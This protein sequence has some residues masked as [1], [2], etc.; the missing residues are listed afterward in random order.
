MQ[1]EYRKIGRMDAFETI[2]QMAT[3]AKQRRG[4][5]SVAPSGQDGRG[6]VGRVISSEEE[7]NLTSDWMRMR[8]HVD[9][10]TSV[11]MA[12]LFDAMAAH[13][14]SLMMKTMSVGGDTSAEGSTSSSGANL[15]E[16]QREKRKRDL[17]NEA[18]WYLQQAESV[19]KQRFTGQ[20]SEWYHRLV[21]GIQYYCKKDDTKAAAEFKHSLSLFESRAARLGHA[22]V[23]IRAVKYVEAI[24]ELSRVYT[25]VYASYREKFAE[26][27]VDGIPS[28]AGFQQGRGPNDYNNPSSDFDYFR[29]T[30]RHAVENAEHSVKIEFLT[31]FSGLR[32]LMALVWSKLGAHDK[33]L[34]TLKIQLD[35]VEEG[36]AKKWI[37]A[38]PPLHDRTLS[39]L[40]TLEMNR[41]TE[42]KAKATTAE[43][44]AAARVVMKDCVS[45]LLRAFQLNSNNP[46]VLNQLANIF[47]VNPTTAEPDWDKIEGFATR[48]KELAQ[49]AGYREICAESCFYLGRSAHARGKFTTAR[50]HYMDAL[51]FSHLFAL[52]RFGLAQLAFKDGDHKGALEH[53]TKLDARIPD[54]ADT[55]AFL[56]KIHLLLAL[57]SSTPADYQT[58]HSSA[59]KFLERSIHLD[60]KRLATHLDLA[61]AKERSHPDRSLD[62]YLDASDLV[63]RG[64]IDSS[65]LSNAE[66]SSL[67]EAML[68]AATKKGDMEEDTKTS[69]YPH[70]VKRF[71]LNTA[72]MVFNNVAVMSMKTDKLTEAKEALLRAILLGACTLRASDAGALAPS[73]TSTQSS[74][75]NQF[76]NP[77]TYAEGKT[78][79]STAVT[80]TALFGKPL[81]EAL[82]SEILEELETFV[83][84]SKVFLLA[85]NV[86]SGYNLALCFEKSK[87]F[88][89]ATE[90]Y[91]A[92]LA[93]YPSYLDAKLRLAAMHK[94]MGRL[95]DAERELKE[96][97]ATSPTKSSSS[98]SITD[99]HLENTKS[100]AGVLLA[101]VLL[102]KKEYRDTKTMLDELV[103]KLSTNRSSANTDPNVAAQWTFGADVYSLTTYA[104]FFL[105]TSYSSQHREKNLKWATDLFM[106]VLKQSPGNIYAANGLAIVH[107]LHA[108]EE[109]AQLAASEEENEPADGENGTSGAHGASSH[110]KIGKST[111]KWTEKSR[112][113][114]NAFL[115][116]REAVPN[117]PDIL[118]NLGHLSFAVGDYRGA[119]KHYN[120]VWK[121]L[122]GESSPLIRMGQVTQM[123]ARCWF[124]LGN[125]DRARDIVASVLPDVA[126]SEGAEGD[127]STNLSSMAAG[128]GNEDYD[129]LRYNWAVMCKEWAT[130]ILSRLDESLKRSS[131]EEAEG[132]NEEDANNESKNTQESK[133]LDV[134]GDSAA[135]PGS[136]ATDSTLNTSSMDIDS[137]VT[138]SQTKTVKSET[139]GKTSFRFVSAPNEEEQKKA[140]DVLNEAK[141]IFEKLSASTIGDEASGAFK[142]RKISFSTKKCV[143]FAKLCEK[144]AELA[145][146]KLEMYREEMKKESVR[147]EEIRQKEEEAEASRQA[148]LLEQEEAIKKQ[149]EA[150]NEIAEA[151][152]LKSQQLM[153]EWVSSGAADLD[154]KKPRK[155]RTSS[156]RGNRYDSD[157][158][159]D[160]VGGNRNPRRREEYAKLPDEEDDGDVD[161]DLFGDD[162]ESDK[163]FAPEKSGGRAPKERTRNRRARAIPSQ[164][165]DDDDDEPSFA[166]RARAPADSNDGDAESNADGGIKRRSALEELAARR[167]A[168]KRGHSDI[169][170]ETAADGSAASTEGVSTSAASAPESTE[171]AGT[172]SVEDPDSGSAPTIKRR[173]LLKGNKEDAADEVD[174]LEIPDGL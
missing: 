56:G 127:A 170:T 105:Q 106:S 81:R 107:A 43:E 11:S 111:A 126:A 171:G 149:I 148:A 140:I 61:Q 72:R 96:L 145:N 87:Q 114:M 48:A 47:F 138:S 134:A 123:L 90:L 80:F 94:E 50:Q 132:D 10:E 165:R 65:D 14:M 104:N 7:M 162:S 164:N 116:I 40:G 26:K 120:M 93:R 21:A 75:S 167:N 98:S 99:S 168:A 158:D 166:S 29:A 119:T 49:A 137:S 141:S 4:Y 51:V 32:P 22:L 113:S 79:L 109:L 39:M 121:Q 2:I 8:A 122:G 63:H 58:H 155:G 89:R 146:E 154:E 86:T 71:N 77:S 30:E 102:A 147:R 91:E 64:F 19:E 95:D 160:D 159:E 28:N 130:N 139:K 169:S 9:Y 68:S 85:M 42:L 143:L 60:R 1:T 142:I 46:N 20:S 151:M 34:E 157:P 117:M 161:P 3:G 36:L 100:L 115:A 156:S 172:T 118:V 125:F 66:Y 23:L 153:E 110:S 16:A 45:H 128:T 103:A 55:K 33:A 74:T 78:G 76:V 133:S 152:R 173:K 174:D 73:S 88:E 136:G 35:A 18:T 163:E 15:S 37:F 92:I 108:K 101:N 84:D 52:P 129:D 13:L 69:L 17:A 97:M 144:N 5:Q 70:F 57:N 67:S 62:S 124:E 27:H 131:G 38:P 53:L 24:E 59:I 112:N 44:V 31:G 54:L 82:P 135:A 83:L 25:S 6:S 150:E 12:M 41:Y